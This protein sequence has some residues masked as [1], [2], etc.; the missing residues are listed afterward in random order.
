MDPALAVLAG[1][2]LPAGEPA[3]DVPQALE[4]IQRLRDRL[5]KRCLERKL[6]A[7]NQR[8]KPERFQA[9]PAMFEDPM[10]AAAE[11][12]LYKILAGCLFDSSTA[13]P[14]DA[15]TLHEKILRDPAGERYRGHLAALS[16]RTPEAALLKLGSPELRC[17]EVRELD[18]NAVPRLFIVHV[19]RVTLS[20]TTGIEDPFAAAAA[21]ASQIATPPPPQPPM[22]PDMM[23][24]GS[25]MAMMANGM[26]GG[27]MMPA[28]GG[29]QQFQGIPG[30]M[31]PGP[32]GMLGNNNHTQMQGLAGR[33]I[34]SSAGMG[35][36]PPSPTPQ[37]PNT[38]H[39]NSQGGGGLVGMPGPSSNTSN[40]MGF[41]NSVM[42]PGGNNGMNGMGKQNMGM[43]MGA[44][45]Q[46]PGQQRQM[47]GGLGGGVGGLGMGQPHIP[48]GPPM[49]Q[50]QQ[51]LG[52]GGGPPPPPPQMPQPQPQ[53]P[54][55]G[56]GPM[57]P[58]PPPQLLQ[59]LGGAVQPL[60]Q[61][62]GGMVGGG[63]GVPPPPP[64]AGGLDPAGKR[65]RLDGVG[66]D[67]LGSLL[68]HK[69]VMDQSK[70]TQ[71]AEDI[72]DLLT[73]PTAK[74][75]TNLGKFRTAGGAAIREHCPQ[76][77]KDEC[78]RVNNSPLACHRV[79]F[80]KQI[81]GYTDV[82]LGNCSY[83]DT[84]RNIR[85]C[86][87]IHYKLDSAP[88]APEHFAAIVSRTQAS[89][90]TYLAALPDPQWVNCDV[91]TFDMNVLG[92]FGVIMTDPPWEIHQDLPYGT[93]ADDEM[94]NLNIGC[95]QDDG[96][97]FVWVT[98]GWAWVT[99]G[100]VGHGWVGGW[101]TGGWVGHGWVGGSLVGGWVTGGWVGH[102]WVGGSQ[103]GGWVTGG[104]VDTDV[105]VAEVRET[106]R[107][108]DEMY[109]LLER[110]SP[111]T[112]KLE[113]FARKHNL[114]QGWVG[115]GNQLDNIS[116]KDPEMRSRFAERYGFEPDETKKE[117]VS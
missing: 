7:S 70:D 34:N 72:L 115:L 29:M 79:H 40:Q 93:M 57:G 48:P 28:F 55:L 43:M 111:G 59:M 90:P 81:Y 105:V 80:L 106:S 46:P 76:L 31:M 66:S 85:N 63:G 102:G 95:L 25:M 94:R 38:A 50:Q 101:V 75:Q 30:M 92:K 41:G 35:G 91:R 12:N 100:W 21:A 77:T 104:H 39:S 67:P 1:A 51:Q 96:V 37:L 114:K 117:S 4:Q 98:G 61:Q 108:P 19:D 36:R 86:K 33:G 8:F 62:Q 87:Y 3:A 53:P 2:G 5:F 10:R 88:D 15:G 6:Q 112:R 56:P 78:R 42:G 16:C 49:Q 26:M 45:G 99:G 60:T 13:L 23:M 44:G 24:P 17:L 113:I 82:S 74:Q 9:L 52:A 11:Q 64:S 69:S 47:Q 22:V 65:Q 97:I 27:G 116:I 110:L 68:G 107:K 14:V 103:V 20:R 89:V 73:K 109:S 71:K 18:V 32:G 83:L 58:P 84:C 54:L